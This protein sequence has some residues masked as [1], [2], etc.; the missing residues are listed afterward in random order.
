VLEDP[1]KAQ[2]PLIHFTD[3]FNAFSALGCS[4]LNDVPHHTLEVHLNAIGSW[5]IDEMLNL[6]V[7]LFRIRDP[8]IAI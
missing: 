6:T 4:G 7:L 3:K 5:I 2:V 8:W 1:F